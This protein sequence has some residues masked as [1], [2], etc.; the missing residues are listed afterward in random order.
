MHARI[1]V[2]A[3]AACGAGK[4][5]MDNKQI[6]RRLFEDGFNHQRA[7][8]I[9]SL[10]APDYVDAAGER[11]PAALTQVMVRLHG[12]FP[13]LAYTVEELVAEGDRVAV[14]WTWKGTHQGAFRTV[15]PTR[16]AVT[17]SG[18]AIF[19]L[20]DGRIVGSALQTDRLGFLQ[21]IGVVPPDG[22]LFQR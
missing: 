1:A 10:V 5:T 4:P 8:V 2:I 21:A 7:D 6:V 17:N 12:A 20:R 22:E 18:A 13:D 9:E 14:R 3:L 15:A 11:G 19:Q 16:R